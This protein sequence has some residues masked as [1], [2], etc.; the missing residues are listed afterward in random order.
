MMIPKDPP[1]R[2]E[3]LRRA[4]A[5]LPCQ[6]CGL[7]GRT[8]ASHSNQQRDGRGMNHKSHDYRIAAICDRCHYDIDY[9][10][11]LSR[12]QK[13]EMW[14][15]AHRKTIGLLFARGLLQVKT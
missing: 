13:V 12:E 15:D 11:D 4:V 9:G 3:A 5:T 14:E 1:Y 8:Q 10:K 2:N 7:E 6:C